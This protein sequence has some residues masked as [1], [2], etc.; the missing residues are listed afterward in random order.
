MNRRIPLIS[1]VFLGLVLGLTTLMIVMFNN[2]GS[3]VTV[4]FVNREPSHGQF[5]SYAESE[6]FDFA[7]QNAGSNP[8]SVYV[9]EIEDER[10]I[11]VP[12]IH[13]L[14]DVEARKSIHHCLYLPLGSHP[15]S[16]RMRV[17]EKASAVRK[18]QFALR[19]LIDKASGRYPGKQ[20]WFDRLR[21]PVYDL[22]VKLSNEVE[23]GCSGQGKN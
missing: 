20:V 22:L 13:E 17:R 15:R 9:S 1:C 12:S 10:G 11:W 5:P 2:R 8:A 7:F 14:G 6:R 18:T 3:K 23:T 4:L 16:L 19:L 21:V